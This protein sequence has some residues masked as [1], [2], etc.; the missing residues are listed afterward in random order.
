MTRQQQAQLLVRNAAIWGVATILA[1]LFP[2]VTDSLTEGRSAFLRTFLPLGL[3]IV[4]MQT[5][6][7][8]IRKAIGPPTDA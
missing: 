2:F 7:A 1:L 8:L 4:G 3:L 5:S 6:N